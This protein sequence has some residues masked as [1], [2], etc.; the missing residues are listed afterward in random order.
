MNRPGSRSLALDIGDQGVGVGRVADD[1]DLDVALGAPRQRL[2][3]RLE[4]AAVGRQ[5]VGSAPCPALRGIAPTSRA[6]SA[7][8]NA[9]SASSV[10][11]IVGEQRERAVVELHAHALERA[12]RRRDLEQL[13]GDGRVR[14][15]HRAG[16]DAEQQAVADLAGGAGDGDTDGGADVM[17][18]ERRPATPPNRVGAA[19]SDPELLE[20][21]VGV[22]VLAVLARGGCRRR[23]SSCPG[24]RW[25][26]PSQYRTL[27]LG[28]CAGRA[29]SLALFAATS[30]AR[31]RGRSARAPWARRQGGE[32]LGRASRR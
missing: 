32:E 8:P 12:E 9:T 23:R 31:R 19:G 20:D 1:E 18:V 11:T 28:N 21:Q 29:C 2:A 4:D 10:H 16:G 3:L 24:S 14:P 17:D 5:Q 7:S 27:T 22:V 26:R 25:P 13:Q 30:V 15:E 6:T